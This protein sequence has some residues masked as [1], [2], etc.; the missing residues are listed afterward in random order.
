[1]LF[2]DLK[3]STKLIRELDPE[4]ARTE[5]SAAIALYRAMEMTV[6]MPQAE[7]ALGQVPG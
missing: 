7:A 3:G 2:A 4:Q 1:M 5:L 6:W